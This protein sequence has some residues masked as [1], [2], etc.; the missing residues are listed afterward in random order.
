MDYYSKVRRCIDWNNEYTIRKALNTLQMEFSRALKA[1]DSAGAKCVLEVVKRLY[2]DF[3]TDYVEGGKGETM[4]YAQKVMIRKF[5]A[6]IAWMDKAINIKPKAT[7]IKQ[8]IEEGGV[9]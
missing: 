5:R 8:I 9:K 6:F 4:S 2:D 3:S 1:G 7:Q